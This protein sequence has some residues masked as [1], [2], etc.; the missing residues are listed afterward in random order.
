[1]NFTI[2]AFYSDTDMSS[3]QKNFYTANGRFIGRDTFTVFLQKT[4]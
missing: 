2:G 1:M 4:F 3:R